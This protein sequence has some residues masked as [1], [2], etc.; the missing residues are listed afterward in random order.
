MEAL[1][2]NSLWSD[3]FLGYHVA[4]VYYWT[5]NVVFLFSPRI[6][7]QFMELLEAHAV[8]TYGTFVVQNRE[9]LAELAYRAS[10]SRYHAEYAVDAQGRLLTCC[11]GADTGLDAQAGT[12]I[13][14]GQDAS[15]LLLHPCHCG[16]DRAQH[17]RLHLQH[18]Q[19][20]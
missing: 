20:V 12:P 10:Y 6:A 17:C 11:D 16:P 14:G 9:R 15:G 18:G 1:G 3:R 4:I 8:D 19:G 13:P 5:L 7:Y 2:G